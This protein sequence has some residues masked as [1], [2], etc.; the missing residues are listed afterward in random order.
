[1]ATNKEMAIMMM[2]EVFT[3]FIAS[4]SKVSRVSALE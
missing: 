3:E 2:D 4:S 1:M